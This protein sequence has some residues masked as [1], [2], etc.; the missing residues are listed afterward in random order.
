MIEF[1]E[2]DRLNDVVHCGSQT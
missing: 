2:L 1:G